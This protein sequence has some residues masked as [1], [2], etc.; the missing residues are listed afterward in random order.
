MDTTKCL[1][2]I[3]LYIIANGQS[4]RNSTWKLGVMGVL[5]GHPATVATE[6]G[7][8]RPRSTNRVRSIAKHFGI[9]RVAPNLR[10]SATPVAIGPRAQGCPALAVID[11]ASVG[12][13]ECRNHSAGIRMTFTRIRPTAWFA[14]P[15][16]LS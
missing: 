8:D 5:R 3:S 2:I 6:V 12:G 16:T 9:A 15:R 7:Y 10:P 1:P 14:G 13:E 11:L 4:R